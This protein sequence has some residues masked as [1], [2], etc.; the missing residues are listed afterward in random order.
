M[1]CGKGQFNADG[2]GNTGAGKASGSSTV[3]MGIGSHE[4]HQRYGEFTQRSVG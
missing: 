1:W 2:P 3:D 4:D